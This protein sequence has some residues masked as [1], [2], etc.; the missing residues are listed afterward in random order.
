MQIKYEKY[1]REMHGATQIKYE[2]VVTKKVHNAMQIGYEK[3]VT[4]RWHGAVQIGFKKSS[5]HKTWR[6]SM[7]IEYEK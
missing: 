2:K 7:Q 5:H 3:V 4:E 6:D 1:S